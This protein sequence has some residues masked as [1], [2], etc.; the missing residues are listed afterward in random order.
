LPQVVPI[1]EWLKEKNRDVN[2]SLFKQDHIGA[3]IRVVVYYV[4]ED[5]KK[6]ESASNIP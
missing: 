6:I 3:N 5:N 4:T 1:K 2:K